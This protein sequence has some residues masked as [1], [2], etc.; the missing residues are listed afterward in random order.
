[1]TLSSDASAMLIGT[2]DVAECNKIFYNTVISMKIGFVNMM[3]DVAER[4][5]HIDADIVCNALKMADRRIIGRRSLADRLQLGCDT[6]GTPMAR[7]TRQALHPARAL[8]DISKERKLS[9]VIY[10][11]R[12][13][14]GLP[15]ADGS[16]GLLIASCIR[17]A[18]ANV[19]FAAP[20]TDDEPDCAGPWVVLLAPDA[21]VSYGTSASESAS[22]YQP[23]LPG[24]V[25]V[26]PW[27]KCP[28]AP[29]IEVIHYDNT[30][31]RPGALSR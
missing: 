6:F 19:S 26:D 9:I 16:C 17:S 22:L 15:Y 2:F 4:N 24:S 23:I 10:G 27:R 14:P 5:G 31:Y 25:V 29:G 20:A 8:V 11:E 12:Y 28:G 1:M 3:Q 7:G 21:S 18:G 30:R 13:K